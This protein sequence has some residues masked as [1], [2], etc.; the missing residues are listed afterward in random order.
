MLNRS[1]VLLSTYILIPALTAACLLFTLPNDG[2]NAFIFGLSKSRLVVASILALLFIIF[3]C[4]TL[5]VFLNWEKSQKWLLDRML[6][7]SGRNF[8]GIFILAMFFLT[9]SAINIP[10][11]Y[12]GEF[13]AINDRIHPGLVWILLT[14]A[15][16]IIGVVGFEIVGRQKTLLP[17]KTLLIPTL[18]ALGT[19][20]VIWIFIAI[21]GLG[22]NSANTFWSKIGVPILWPQ[23]ILALAIGLGIHFFRN[24]FIKTASI[25]IWFDFLLLAV[26]WLVATILWNNQT[27][28]PGVFNTTPRPP[29]YE[30]YPINDSQIFDVGAQKLLIGQRMIADVVDKPIYISFLA[31]IHFLA[32]FSYAQFYLYQVMFF[33]LIPVCGYLIGKNMHSIS[34][35]VMFAVVLVCKEL[36]AIELTNYIHVST[37]KMILSEMLTTLGLLLFVYFLFEWMKSLDFHNINL[38]LAGGVLGITSLVRLNSIGILPFAI[39]LIGF[40]LKFNWRRWILSGFL[41][42]IFVIIATTPWAIRNE[43]VSGDPFNFIRS[44]TSGVL[45]KQRYDPIINSTQSSGASPSRQSSAILLSQNVVN[46]YLHNLIGITLMLPPSTQLYNALDLVK[47]PYWKLDWAGALLPGGFWIIVCVLIIA[48]VGVGSAWSRFGFAG[49]VPLVVVLGYNSTTAISFTSGGRYLVPID[50]GLLLYFSLGLLTTAFGL[51]E[52]FGG[53]KFPETTKPVTSNNFGNFK[54]KVI[55]IGMLFLVFGSIP[56]GLEFLPN[57]AY[58]PSVSMADFISANQTIPELGNRGNEV[59]L[60][61]LEATPGA[62]VLYGRALYPRYFG[63]NKGDG[64]NISQDPLIGSA[65]FDHLS[66][67]MIGGNNTIPVLLPANDIFSPQIPGSD[68]WVIGCKRQNYVEAIIVVFRQQNY[69]KTYTEDTPAKTCQ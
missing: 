1:R 64:L 37:S 28:Q 38:Y 2:P 9:M 60:S 24:R 61:S 16:L 53:Y 66:F 63:Q 7:K 33:A 18:I 62:I 14:C 19:F 6:T 15:Q 44:K 69:I 3:I 4:L 45:E 65:G 52:L 49:L 56:T 13:I 42:S 40:S 31:I 50:W 55:A 27:Y 39:L 20:L 35:G 21:T 8:F 48:A 30:V 23:I 11:K 10:D 41:L 54:S 22:V 36:N 17:K 29:T 5:L 47:L 34:L 59:S 68:T 32:G 51:V 43:V 25:G 67:L 46:N 58:P 26:I 12:L 57:M